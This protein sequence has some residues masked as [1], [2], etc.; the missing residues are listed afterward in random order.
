M[1]NPGAPLPHGSTFR[2]WP[3]FAWEGG[4]LGPNPRL[5]VKTR[6][7]TSANFD[8]LLTSKA[9][10]KAAGTAA[11]DGGSALTSL[12]FLFYTSLF[13]FFFSTLATNT[14][15]SPSPIPR[16]PAG[17]ANL[18]KFKTTVI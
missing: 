10:P 2:S 7:A 12:L 3:P 17:Q 11:Y 13:L 4:L 9:T 5:A 6:S 1:T 18:I 15:P 14:P 16:F 8:L